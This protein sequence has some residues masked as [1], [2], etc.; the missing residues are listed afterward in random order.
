MIPSSRRVRPGSRSEI[1]AAHNCDEWANP[2]D[3]PGYSHKPVVKRL[4]RLGVGRLRLMGVG[5]LFSIAILKT[6]GRIWL[7]EDADVG[8]AAVKCLVNDGCVSEGFWS[9]NDP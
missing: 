9:V 2:R 1:D 4:P 7:P 3:G 5:Q 6:L 8:P